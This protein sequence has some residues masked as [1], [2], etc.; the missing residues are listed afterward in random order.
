VQGTCADYT[1][2]LTANRVA[3]TLFTPRATYFAGSI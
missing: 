1:V 2:S 3:R